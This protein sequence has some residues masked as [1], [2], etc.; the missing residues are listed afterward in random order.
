MPGD[1]AYDIGYLVGGIVGALIVAYLV[2]WVIGS[3]RNDRD[4]RVAS[5]RAYAHH[6]RTL[7]LAAV[8]YAAV[9]LGRFVSPG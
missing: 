4:R 2:M 9:L 5:G 1:A 6:Y 8:L 7:W 3:V